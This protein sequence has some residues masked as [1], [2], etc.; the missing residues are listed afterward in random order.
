MT[1]QQFAKGHKT[2]LRETCT[3]II[4]TATGEL[5]TEERTTTSK[6]PAEPDYIKLYYKTMLTATGADDIPLAFVM[7]LSA[8]ITYANGD[9]EMYFYNNKT[10]RSAIGAYCDISDNM[11]AKRIRLCVDKG[12]L[13]RTKDRG[14]YLINPWILAKGKWTHI[15][16]LQANYEYVDG[17]WQIASHEIYPTD[18]TDVQPTSTSTPAP[19]PIPAPMPVYAQPIMQPP[20][21]ATS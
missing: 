2:I 6:I 18:Q 19:A 21:A 7:A 12:V 13:M 3:E 9:G 17:T 20:M 8:H 16:K 4:D 14:T 15:R 1:E 5:L 10:T 11:V